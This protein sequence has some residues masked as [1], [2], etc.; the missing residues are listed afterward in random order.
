MTL[1]ACCVGPDASLEESD[2]KLDHQNRQ[3]ETDRGSE[4]IINTRTIAD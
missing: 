1:L 3:S 2:E 4:E